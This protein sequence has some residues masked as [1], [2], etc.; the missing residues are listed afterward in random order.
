MHCILYYQKP[1]IGINSQA[2]KGLISYFKTNGITSFK[3]HLDVV[4]IIA[5]MFE[6]EI[7]FLLK[8]NA[9]R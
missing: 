9:K 8:G 4:H 7:N 1:I 3:K 6:E 2:R 5:K